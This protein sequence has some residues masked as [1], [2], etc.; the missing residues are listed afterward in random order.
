MESFHKRFF[1]SRDIASSHPSTPV[2]NPL[3]FDIILLT[4]QGYQL[5][6][7]KQQFH[8][9]IKYTLVHVNGFHA[10][11]HCHIMKT[12]TITAFPFN[13]SSLIEKTNERVV[14]LIAISRLLSAIKPTPMK[15]ALKKGKMCCFV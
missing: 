7:S 6:S 8:I 1:I 11:D 4:I 10:R 12:N 15:C 13:E 9:K 14:L 5:D 2:D 3:W